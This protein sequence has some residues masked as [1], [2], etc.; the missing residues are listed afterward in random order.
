V[1]RGI[2]MRSMSE[3]IGSLG[4]E[5]EVRSAPGAGTVVTGRLGVVGASIGT[6][7]RHSEI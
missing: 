2:G 6:A 7:L 4:G 1:R 3:R 5:L